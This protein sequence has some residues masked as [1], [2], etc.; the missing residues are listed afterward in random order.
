[1]SDKAVQQF[2]AGGA[3]QSGPVL[4]VVPEKAVVR[5]GG[6]PVPQGADQAVVALRTLNIVTLENAGDPA[7][8]GVQQVLAQLIAAGEVVIQQT[9]EVLQIAID[10][11]KKEDRHP[12][13]LQQLIE[14]AVWS[15]QGGFGALHQHGAD[16]LVQK[17]QKDFPL[18]ADL[19]LR[20]EYQGA[21]AGLGK[22]RLHIV[23]NG[24]EDIV[25]QKG[26]DNGNLVYIVG[27]ARLADVGAAALTALD[28]V[29]L[30]QQL[31]RVADSLAAHMVALGQFGLRGKLG[32]PLAENLL[33][34]TAEDGSQ[35]FVF[36]GQ[37]EAPPS[38]KLKQLPFICLHY[39]RYPAKCAGKT[40]LFSY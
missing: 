29:L 36:C 34:L 8:T 26:G 27:P 3:E 28:E 35:L 6:L 32:A 21:V 25:V 23:K 15:G 14:V 20:G 24:G 2:A 39:S 37:I 19:V 40:C 16:C 18:P 11:V 22:G 13:C 9:G 4:A 38:G 30:L 33:N 1:M 31:Q 5:D 10:S 12:F 7:V 17:L